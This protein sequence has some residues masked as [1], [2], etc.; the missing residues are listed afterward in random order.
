MPVHQ[1]KAPD[2]KDTT[3]A[4]HRVS[5]EVASESNVQLK[6]NR[7]DTV[8]QLQ[9]IA[10]DSPQVNKTAQLQVMAN[11][12]TSQ[13][14]QPIQKKENNTG[15]PDNLK[16]GVENLSGHSMDD[17]KVHYNSNKPAQLNAHAYAQGTDIHL[18]SGQEKHLPHEAWHVVQQKQ[19]KVKPTMQ[20]KGNPST[21]LRAG[22]NVNDDAGL[23][24]EADV[25]GA[26]ALQMT[27]SNSQA[28]VQNKN[29]SRKTKEIQLKTNPTKGVVQR[30]LTTD[31][32]N[33][34]GENHPESNA[35]RPKE[36]NF[37]KKVIG[38]GSGYWEEHQF[39]VEGKTDFV[40][41]KDLRLAYLLDKIISFYGPIF[42]LAIKMAGSD[43]P[44]LMASKL[45]AIKKT[46]QKGY[47]V[48]MIS[49]M[50]ELRENL[51]L[52]KIKK[53]QLS[54]LMS[55]TQFKMLYQDMNKYKNVL[56]QQIIDID[57]YTAKS[58]GLKDFFLEIR[59]NSGRIVILATKSM[60]Q[61]FKGNRNFLEERS[62]KMHEGGNLA[63]GTPG[64]WKIGSLH[65]KDIRRLYKDNVINYNLIDKA[66]FNFMLENPTPSEAKKLG[67]YNNKKKKK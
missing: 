29:D 64:I 30:K 22:V 47:D 12:F 13:Q 33:V 61:N 15:L 21:A 17:V 18:G 7:L 20:M 37:T 1:D 41:P 45:P 31:K 25:M 58:K 10:N 26:K 55:I 53:G 60:S 43:D 4:Q 48:F 19:G 32:L 38:Q 28:V 34:I 54:M 8:S 9:I 2:K 16:S 3:N 51:N 23:E 63:A 36:I 11:Q 65:V 6:D 67:L 62:V 40:D 59:A 56:S 27:T 44:A 24:K 52:I 14:F 42:K 39:V 66:K 35:R 49:L 46:L 5:E 50:L 57:T